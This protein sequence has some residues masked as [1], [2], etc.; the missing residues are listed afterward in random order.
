MCG[1]K[2]N[3]SPLLILLAVLF[4]GVLGPS[5]AR[6][7]EGYYIVP[8]LSVVEEYDDNIFSDP[9]DQQQDDFITRFTPGV[10]I[11]YQSERFTLLGHYSTGAEVWAQHSDFDSF[12]ANQLADGSLQYEATPRLSI[13]ASGGYRTSQNPRDVNAAPVP[14]QPT[15]APPPPPAPPD[16]TIVGTNLEGPRGRSEGFF[17]TPSASYELTPLTTVH[18]NYG[19]STTSQV[20]SASN[21][22]HTAA[23]TI[24]RR[25][26]ELDTVSLDYTFRYT[27]SGEDFVTGDD[28]IDDNETS[29]AV[30]GGWSRPLTALTDISLRGGAR[31]EQGDVSPETEAFLSRR[32]ERGAVSISYIRTQTISVGVAGPVEVQ[33]VSASLSYELLE[34]LGTGINLSYS[35]NDQQ[36]GSP[37]DSYRAAFD[38]SYPIAE[39]ASVVL[40]YQFS[41]QDGELSGSAQAPGSN[42]EIYHNLVLLGVSASYPY[43]LY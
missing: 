12:V 21:Q 8:S 31:F 19:Y 33:T 16:V 41:F 3:V 15:G 42:D 14:L 25:L 30:T 29:H 35:R 7:Q 22:Q 43:R 32:L 39:W 10:Q 18:G 40:S 11:G 28:Q 2:G 4:T 1:T 20:G 13:S 6:A 27:S 17:A 38:A 9:P 36:G 24:D 37:I 26:T 5:A 34:Y 23:A